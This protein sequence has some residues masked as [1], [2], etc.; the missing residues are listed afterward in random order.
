MSIEAAG[1]VKF[2]KDIAEL[3]VQNKKDEAL[4]LSFELTEMDA[5]EVDDFLKKFDAKAEEVLTT[6]NTMFQAHENPQS[7]DDSIESLDN[8]GELFEEFTKLMAE[9]FDHNFAFRTNAATSRYL[10]SKANNELLS[11][12][13]DDRHQVG[14]PEHNSD[15]DDP[16]LS[17]EL[18]HFKLDEKKLL[19]YSLTEGSKEEFLE[20]VSSQLHEWDKRYI[21]IRGNEIA[22]KATE[23]L[24]KYTGQ[25]ETIL[26]H[27]LQR[28]KVSVWEE[29][30]KKLTASEN[31]VDFSMI[32]PEKPDLLTVPVEPCRTDKKYNPEVGILGKLFGGTRKKQEL[33]T[34]ELFLT[35]SEHWQNEKKSIELQNQELE[36]KYSADVKTFTEQK[37]KFEKRQKELLQMVE[38]KKK[39]YLNHDPEAIIDYCQ[40]L[41]DIP[42]SP[43]KIPCHYDLDYLV[44]EKAIIV[45]CLMPGEATPPII[46]ALEF[47]YISDEVDHEKDDYGFKQVC[48]NEAE[49]TK[50][51]KDIYMQIALGTIYEIFSKDEAK[52]IDTIVFN[53]WLALSIPNQDQD[54][55]LCIISIKANKNSFT[56]LDLSRINHQA[57]FEQLKGRI[58]FAG[59]KIQAVE[60][61]TVIAKNNQDSSLSEKPVLTDNSKGQKKTE[62]Q[63]AGETINKAPDVP[64]VSPKQEPTHPPHIVED[65]KRINIAT[66]DSSSNIPEE[67][68]E[69][70]PTIDFAE[71]R[72]KIKAPKQ[73]ERKDALRELYELKTDE[74]VIL[75]GKTVIDDRSKSVRLLAA[76]LLAKFGGKKTEDFFIKALN[77]QEI[78]IRKIAISA[79]GSIDDTD[80]SRNILL[81][82]L[83]NRSAEIRKT[84]IDAMRQCK[85]LDTDTEIQLLNVLKERLASPHKDERLEA[86]S[87]LSDFK[88]V[89]II[90][91]IGN[92]MFK[93]RSKAIKDKAATIMAFSFGGEEV[94]DWMLKALA[95]KDIDNQV[96]A[97]RYLGTVADGKTCKDVLL[98][99]MEHDADPIKTAAIAALCNCYPEMDED[100]R[101]QYITFLENNIGS[102]VDDIY[103]FSIRALLLIDP[104]PYIDRFIDKLNNIS[105]V[106]NILKRDSKWYWKQPGIYKSDMPGL[107]ETIIRFSDQTRLERMSHILLSQFQTASFENFYFYSSVTENI[108]AVFA[109]SSRA[110]EIFSSLKQ[111]LLTTN[112]D[113]EKTALVTILV[114]LIEDYFLHPERTPIAEEHLQ[115]NV[116]VKQN[117]NPT[118]ELFKELLKKQDRSSVK[119]DFVYCK[120]LMSR[121]GINKF[122][123]HRNEI[124]R[125][126]TPLLQLYGVDTTELEAIQPDSG[127]KRSNSRKSRKMAYE[128]ITE[129]LKVPAIDKKTISDRQDNPLS[130]ETIEQLGDQ[131]LNGK[132]TDDRM[133]AGQ[134]LSKIDSE[135]V[136]LFMLK[137]TCDNIVKV[138]KL[139]WS[140]I[141]KFNSDETYHN[142]IEAL[143]KGVAKIS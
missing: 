64:I 60:K 109:K 1:K 76:T 78:E 82:L 138:R 50:S 67:E 5:G 94:K 33:K 61:F 93:D 132:K 32:P 14:E 143:K 96:I 3:L 120:K 100:S 57:C 13:F 49:L 68:I 116:W 42:F 130:S 110:D 6:I 95:S 63:Q 75:I 129:R 115:K 27:T 43:E 72:K 52:A 112:Q 26:H 139:A 25:H 81:P 104:E 88:N 74:A 40:M 9:K 66:E 12:N 133:S 123:K 126:L 55:R 54:E 18:V 121:L 44:N 19:S 34:E 113:K 83:E 106:P 90:D 111:C 124:T 140:Y 62:E 56:K 47:Y 4:N 51:H 99:L 35:D 135:Q 107:V 84:T 73:D 20:K 22:Q 16:R 70:E 97:V 85:N 105:L 31:K 142:M 30:L 21:T 117:L 2:Y 23:A 102:S 101:K 122:K 7:P 79:L 89:E 119:G 131:L 39:Y 125:Y 108:L 118:I 46:K 29:Y 45:D 136:Y 15:P 37:H 10:I 128:E 38:E 41:L 48:M 134:E 86:L 77:D 53:G 8:F 137:A 87:E 36:E 69:H 58:N 24:Q 11:I 17:V 71:A 65:H 127:K 114:Y 80:T 59:S 91:L 141:A 98:P 103:S 28:K 92:K